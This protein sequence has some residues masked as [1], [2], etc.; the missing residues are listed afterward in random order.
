MG[1][2]V[3]S[4]VSL[5]EAVH[6]HAQQGWLTGILQIP[7][8]EENRKSIPLL[9]R[10][11]WIG[12]RAVYYAEHQNAEGIGVWSIMYAAA[13]ATALKTLMSSIAHT[14]RGID[15]AEEILTRMP[16]GDKKSEDL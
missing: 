13:D 1:N 4:D 12:K 2:M 15:A 9:L 3:S 14:L 7:L 16:H 10:G 6:T 11:G 8:R 5:R